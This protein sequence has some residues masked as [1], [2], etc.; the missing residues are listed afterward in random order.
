VSEPV[1]TPR[2]ARERSWAEV[3]WRQARNPP[4]PVLRAVLA[5]LAVASVGGAALLL[6]DIAV[7]RGVSLPGG[8]LRTLAA[9]VYVVAVLVLG[10]VLTW[11]WVAL[12]TGVGTE[13]RRSPWALLLGFFAAAPIVYLVL[14]VAFQIL[15]PLLV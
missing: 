6:Y 5:N 1:G 7:T 2:Q 8:D 12:P 13:R 15:R 10:S 4:P 14:V 11:R 9:L 3:R